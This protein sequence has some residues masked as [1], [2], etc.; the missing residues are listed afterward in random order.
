ML[1]NSDANAGRTTS[2]RKHAMR[3]V[4]TN[5]MAGYASTVFS[6]SRVRRSCSIQ[7][8]SCCIIS[9]NRPAASPTATIST[10]M[11]GNTSLCSA[12]ASE[13]GRPCSTLRRKSTSS[14]VS[15]S[16]PS[17][18]SD[19]RLSRSGMPECSK[20]ANWRQMSPA[21]TSP[22]FVHSAETARF[23]CGARRMTNCPCSR[24]SSSASASV[25]AVHVPST[26]APSAVRAR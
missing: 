23:L 22:R 17:P 15:L 10:A 16:F 19:T 25:A 11:G 3:S 5:K 21:S 4:S 13:N 7:S 20:T 2:V 26:S 12:S 18:A 1:T 8:A 24:I 14:A 9:A 6:F